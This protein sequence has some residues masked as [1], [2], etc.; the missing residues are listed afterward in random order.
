MG[1]I[2]LPLSTCVLSSFVKFCFKLMQK[3]SPKIHS[4]SDARTAIF[5]DRM[6][7]KHQLEYL[8][9]FFKLNSAAAKEN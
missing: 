4:Q 8:L 3:R 5:A 7:R 1:P 9:I 6:Y 2:I